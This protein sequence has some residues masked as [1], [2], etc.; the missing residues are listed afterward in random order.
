MTIFYLLIIYIVGI[1]L[2]AIF[3]VYGEDCDKKVETIIAAWILSI[4]WPMT[5][6]VC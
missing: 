6:S 5:L 2:M 4:F 1:P 3:L